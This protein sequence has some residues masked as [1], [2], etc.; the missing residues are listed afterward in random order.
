MKDIDSIKKDIFE[1]VNNYSDIKFSKK[2][3]SARYFRDSCRWK[4]YR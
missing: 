1:L 3:I 4:I 2:R